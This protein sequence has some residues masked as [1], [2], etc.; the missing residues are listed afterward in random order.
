MTHIERVKCRVLQTDDE[1]NV[2]SRR[3][4]KVQAKS[5]EAH[6]KA[7]EERATIRRDLDTVRQDLAKITCVSHSKLIKLTNVMTRD[8]IDNERRGYNSYIH[9]LHSSGRSCRWRR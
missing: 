2:V 5:D 3:C 1:L 9:L 4:A 8:V 6:R 7:E